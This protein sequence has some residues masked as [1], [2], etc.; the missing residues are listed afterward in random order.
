MTDDSN[1]PVSSLTPLDRAKGAGL[2]PNPAMD[3]K[4]KAILQNALSEQSVDVQRQLARLR[5]ILIHIGF[6]FMLGGA[7]VLK[8][9]VLNTVPPIVL[10]GQSIDPGL[11]LIMAVLWV[12]GQFGF[13][14]SMQV[15]ALKIAKLEPDKLNQLLSLRPPAAGNALSVAPPPSAASNVTNITTPSGS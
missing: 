3:A 13:P 8:V 11:L 2:A 7:V 10:A 5:V 4:A 6:L 15:L 9:K 14:G 1:K 12:W